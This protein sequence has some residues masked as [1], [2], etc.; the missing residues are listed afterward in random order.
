MGNYDN[1]L[2]LSGVTT[3][4]V[5]DLPLSKFNAPSSSYN[6][7]TQNSLTYSLEGQYVEIDLY[8]SLDPGATT[9]F[10]GE[11][12]GIVMKDANDNF[13]KWRERQFLVITKEQAESS[14]WSRWTSQLFVPRLSDTNEQLQY[15][16]SNEIIFNLKYISENELSG[17]TF[18]DR[19]LKHR[20]DVNYDVL[21]NF[22]S[23]NQC[24]SS[25]IDICE[26]SK[27]V[28][29]NSFENW[30]YEYDIK[31]YTDPNDTIITPNS[32]NE[33]QE[34]WDENS[35]TPQGS[36]LPLS[37]IFNA[38][39]RFYR[40]KGGFF[41]ETGCHYQTLCSAILETGVTGYGNEYN[42]WSILDGTFWLPLDPHWEMTNFWS[43]VLIH[44]LGH[45]LGLDHS[46]QNLQG[47]WNDIFPELEQDGIDNLDRGQ[48]NP[49]SPVW[50]EGEFLMVYSAE[51]NNKSAIMSY[52]ADWGPNVGGPQNPLHLIDDE[53]KI[54][55]NPQYRDWPVNTEPMSCQFPN[56]GPRN[57]NDE[58]AGDSIYVYPELSLN[59]ISF[60]SDGEF[61]EGEITGMTL[62]FTATTGQEKY[63][64]FL[65]FRG[66]VDMTDETW[67]DG[68]FYTITPYNNSNQSYY[69]V[70]YIKDPLQSIPA[71]IEVL[72]TGATQEVT[73][74]TVV[75][76]ISNWV[77]SGILDYS[78]LSSF[79]FEIKRIYGYGNILLEIDDLQL[80]IHTTGGTVT[81]RARD[82]NTIFSNNGSTP[83]TLKRP[84]I[85]FDYADKFTTYESGG[86]QP[87]QWVYNTFF[88][89][90]SPR[91]QI[92]FQ[93]SINSSF[94]TVMSS[95]NLNTF[96]RVDRVLD[97]DISGKFSFGNIVDFQVDSDY[98]YVLRKDTNVSAGDEFFTNATLFETYRMTDYLNFS[99]APE[100]EISNVYL[101]SPNPSANLFTRIKLADNG[102]MYL[103]NESLVFKVDIEG[104]SITGLKTLTID[105]LV[106]EFL[107]IGSIY[108]ILDCKS[109]NTNT[110]LVLILDNGYSKIKV[111]NRDEPA[112]TPFVFTI[113]P[114]S[115]DPTFPGRLIFNKNSINYDLIFG[116]ITGK[117]S[118]ITG[119]TSSNGFEIT[120]TGLDLIYDN[121]S[122]VTNP[123]TITKSCVLKNYSDV[124][125][126]FYNNSSP[127][128]F[129][130]S[131]LSTG[132]HYLF[133]TYEPTGVLPVVGDKI[134]GLTYNLGYK[135]N[136]ETLQNGEKY[137]QVLGF[138]SFS[139]GFTNF[140]N[141]DFPILDDNNSLI[142]YEFDVVPGSENP[143]VVNF[144]G[145][146]RIKLFIYLSS[147]YN[148]SD[149]LD[150]ISINSD[151]IS[152]LNYFSASFEETAETYNY[153]FNFEVDWEIFDVTIPSPYDVTNH[154]QFKSYFTDSL[155]GSPKNYSGGSP[156]I[157]VNITPQIGQVVEVTGV[158]VISIDALTDQL[159]PY[160]S[161]KVPEDDLLD[162]DGI[163]LRL[164]VK[165]VGYVLGLKNSTDRGWGSVFDDL[166]ID[167]LDTADPNFLPGD[168]SV[169]CCQTGNQIV[170]MPYYGEQSGLDGK[171]V[172]VM[173][174][175]GFNTDYYDSPFNPQGLLLE[176]KIES[177][178][179]S[180]RFN[181]DQA[182]VSGTSRNVTLINF[183]DNLE[184][185]NP[186]LDY[187]E[188][189]WRTATSGNLYEDEVNLISS[190]S[191][192][193]FSLSS[194][195]TENAYH[196]LIIS[197]SDLNSIF[198]LDDQRGFGIELKR[199][200][201]SNPTGSGSVWNLLSSNFR[202]KFYLNDGTIL[203][204][205][206][207]DLYTESR[208]TRIQS[209]ATNAT[210]TIGFNSYELDIIK[211]N[212]N[213]Y[214]Y[215][216][217]KD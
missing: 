198:D 211:R 68:G 171:K 173:S 176:K 71:D 16:N 159:T 73:K 128:L 196:Q 129:F 60:M 40:Q 210:Q 3:G 209:Y 203:E 105:D 20:I 28:F 65:Y 168:V 137:F 82:Y 74:E 189:F 94:E 145:T 170:N 8:I 72:Y 11:V 172:S 84:G 215:N 126:F 117:L 22:D 163:N 30:S 66:F 204:K 110:S 153:G 58:N 214:L 80:S 63:F 201:T 199:T 98:F 152:T 112:V 52:D 49:F 157:A 167:S 64:T 76:D 208:G 6:Q 119:N 127:N 51:T 24:L 206:A 33:A 193:Y 187:I 7:T 70:F 103:F 160:I 15:V 35:N 202:I 91:D 118:K 182:S 114:Y 212:L 106:T 183:L 27:E 87:T 134:T 18:P 21:T 116:D 26:R 45:C 78:D 115:Q 17:T 113:P 92:N 86:T 111:V 181:I 200:R 130:L 90:T 123:I 79:G 81:R 140:R 125:Y 177:P 67:T 96:S 85:V 77:S 162:I 50:L 192:N 131:G 2:Y 41:K 48:N 38:S 179:T 124:N 4:L 37:W 104:E 136:N 216:Y 141:F 135:V 29:N 154:S 194:G 97:T 158:G 197:G 75:T 178:D 217:Y 138:D 142:D 1:K 101:A 34:I 89:L 46:F 12:F 54:F 155:S 100:P 143:P 62:S 139:T 165:C 99:F 42:P 44:E 55:T 195:E 150:F 185:G 83:K 174:N 148:E 149:G 69:S 120:P 213:Y 190:G 25:F 13:V 88:G 186:A 151:L 164:F 10:P 108:D 121:F 36:Y 56:R 39:H 31:I 61:S 9:N 23:Y 191:T 166:L 57:Y 93:L 133:T 43:K 19:I 144:D 95:I 5:I 184:I 102:Q 109:G 122:G 32:R 14:K 180:T 161:I 169:S 147:F 47:G 156:H 53:Y 132:Y 59:L 107:N 205:R 175:G 207:K 188:V 146:I